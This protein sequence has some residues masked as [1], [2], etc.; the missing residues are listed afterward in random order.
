MP[1][2]TADKTPQTLTDRIKALFALSWVTQFKDVRAIGLLI[3][4]VIALM[5]SWSGA[6]VIQTNYDLQKQI[7]QMQQENQVSELANNN[8]KLENQYFN[9]D[10]YQELKARQDFGLGAPGEKLIMVSREVA[11]AHTVSTDEDKKVATPSSKKPQYQKNFES[12][13]SF[14]LHRDQSVEL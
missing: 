11:L 1:E 2:E 14:F 5:V 9:T 3:F 4:L 8:L 13:I 6:K 12:W 10:Q 7:S